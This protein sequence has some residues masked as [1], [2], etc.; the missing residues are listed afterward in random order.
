MYVLIS[1]EVFVSTYDTIPLEVGRW[2]DRKGKEELR[3]LE[4]S[5]KSKQC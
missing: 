1:M 5:L 4:S 3:R 2:L